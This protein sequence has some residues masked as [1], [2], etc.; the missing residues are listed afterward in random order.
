[1]NNIQIL[2]S[3]LNEVLFYSSLRKLINFET[4]MLFQYNEKLSKHKTLVKLRFQ[5]KIMDIF[6]RIAYLH[7]VQE[8]L[9]QQISDSNKKIENSKIKMANKKN[10]DKSVIRLNSFYGYILKEIAMKYNIQ[11]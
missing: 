6:K 5:Q 2:V 7:Q 9:N 4:C 3:L 10:M 11:M 1:M 8:L